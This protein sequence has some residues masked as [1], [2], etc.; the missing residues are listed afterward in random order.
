MIKEFFLF[1]KKRN[2]KI[3]LKDK[4]II[5]K[6][7]ILLS[8]K[9]DITGSDNTVI[10]EEGGRLNGRVLIIG[11]KNEIRIGKN[12]FIN[13]D[14]LLRA[15]GDENKIIIGKNVY[16][17]EAKLLVKDATRITIGDFCLFS[18]Q[19]DIQASDGHSI[20]QIQSATKTK[21]N[22]SKDVK[23]GKHVWICRRVQILKGSC[24]PDDCVV[25]AGTMINKVFRQ[26]N[27]VIAGNPARIIKENI[28]W[29][30]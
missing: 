6:L 7:R 27:V 30:F 5:K 16:I 29:K 13:N 3:I 22:Q 2:N 8:V 26:S 18:S 19:I 1:L 28:N 10:F 17:G 24:I 23:I 14:S 9:W 4:N 20:Y 21:I 15:E 12:C 11:N 25:G